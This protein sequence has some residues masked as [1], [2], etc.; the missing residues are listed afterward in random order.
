MVPVKVSEPVP[1]EEMARRIDHLGRL[2]TAM[3][4]LSGGEPLTH[5]QLDGIIRRIRKTGAIAGMITNG[6]LLSEERIERLNRAGLDHMH[7]S[8]QAV[9][10]VLQ[11]R[12]AQAGPGGRVVLILLHDAGEHLAGAVEVVQR[13]GARHERRQHGARLQVLLRQALIE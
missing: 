5:P 7:L 4:G 1:F 13:A 12:D 8:A 6:Y 3:I 11:V 9:A 2:G 10:R